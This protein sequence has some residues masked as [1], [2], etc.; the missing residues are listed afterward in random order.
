MSDQNLTGEVWRA[1]PR[2]EGL[3]LVSNF[4]RV[5]SVERTV[6]RSNGRP[7]KVA[8]KLRKPQAVARG[9]L[10]VMLSNLDGTLSGVYIHRLVLEAFV[11]PRPE[12]KIALHRDGDPTHNHVSNLYWGTYSDNALDSVRHRTHF[13]ANKTHCP[14]GHE[15]TAENT[16]TWENERHCRKCWSD[17][18]RNRRESARNK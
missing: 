7:H 11:E 1:A 6:I 8:S 4:G 5:R 18:K 12:G 10:K 9:H 2:F 17:H 3:Y 14:Q 15:Y 16:Y 13:Q